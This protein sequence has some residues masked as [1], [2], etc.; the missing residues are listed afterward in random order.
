[1]KCLKNVEKPT[2]HSFRCGEAESKTVMTLEKSSRPIKYKTKNINNSNVKRIILG[3]KRSE[4][5]RE[6]SPRALHGVTAVTTKV[7]LYSVDSTY[8]LSYTERDD[9]WFSLFLS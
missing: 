4:R 5:S 9:C 7:I 1:M 8:Y 3:R 2:D 6:K